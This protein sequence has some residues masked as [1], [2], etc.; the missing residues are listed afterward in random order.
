M[1]YVIDTNIVSALMRGETA[2]VRH[3]TG[4]RPDEVLLPHPV[5]A[6]IRYGLARLGRS[7]R[8]AALEKRADE[9]F[10]AIDRAPWTDEVS[11][12]FAETKSDLERRGVRLEDMDVII[13][14]HALATSAT[15]VTRNVRQLSRIR[16]LRIDDW[17]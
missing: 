11:V 10:A 2:C 12:S 6:E 4:A 3:F 9:L 16:G 7:R 14:A 1:T 5:V 17:M 15:L 13:A 8:K